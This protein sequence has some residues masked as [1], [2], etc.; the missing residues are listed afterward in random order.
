LSLFLVLGVFRMNNIG[1]K[2]FDLEYMDILA[3][4]RSPL[5]RLDPRAKLMTTLLFII[6]VVSFGKYTLLA[7]IPFLM[8]PVFLVSAGGLP[9]GYFMK[10]ILTVLPFVLLMGIFNP[11]IDRTIVARVGAV[12]ISG[13]WVSFLSILLRFFLTA[14]SALL[15]IAL[16]GFNAVCGAL[17]NLGVPKPFIVQLMFFYRYLFVLGDEAH[18]MDRARALRSSPAGMVRTKTFFS[19]TGHL[20]LRT[21]ERAE[22]IYRAMNCR[23]FD[24]RVPM[25]QPGRM[26]VRDFGFMAGWSFLFFAFRV[27][28]VP[29]TLGEWLWGSLR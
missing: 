19:M 23:G 7:L 21:F 10:K 28:N 11:V 20:L 14:S 16:T 29:L 13:G 1:K 27:Y 3:R 25:L 15:L 22:R 2:Y 4:G 5:H 26:S 24:G 6:T 17:T 12:D 9:A 8:Y 18:G